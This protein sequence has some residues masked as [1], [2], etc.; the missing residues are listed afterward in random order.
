MTKYQSTY[1]VEGIHLLFQTILS[2]QQGNEHTRSQH[3][4]EYLDTIDVIYIIDLMTCKIILM[5]AISQVREVQSLQGQRL[6][7]QYISSQ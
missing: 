2:S 1:P 3:R 6:G 7:L 5:S 4:L